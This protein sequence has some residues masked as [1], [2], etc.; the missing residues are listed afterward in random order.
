[1]FFFVCLV[2]FRDKYLPIDGKFHRNETHPSPTLHQST[3]MEE[4]KEGEAADVRI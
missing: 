2:F 3:S 1:M 4:R